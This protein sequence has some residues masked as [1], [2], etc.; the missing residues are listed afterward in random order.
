MVEGGSALGRVLVFTGIVFAKA[1]RQRTPKETDLHKSSLS[2]PA[3]P[4]PARYPLQYPHCG[5]QAI[6]GVFLF[7][8][9]LLLYMF[10]L[11]FPISCSPKPF[12]YIGR[13]AGATDATAATDAARSPRNFCR[14]PSSHSERFSSDSESA[15]RPPTLRTPG[16]KTSDSEKTTLGLR[17]N[18]PRTPRK[19]PSDSE[20]TTLGLTDSEKTTLGLT[21]SE[22]TILGLREDNPRTPSRRSE[23][24]R[25]G[26]ECRSRWSP[27]H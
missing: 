21:D 9:L 23:E 22:K 13:G 2:T 8:H 11:C 15:V 24:R 16:R 20:K 17:E 19:Q 5:G 26:K 12:I 6:L 14:T 18:N 1:N 27:Y 3:G 7:Y 25:V 4:L 10:F